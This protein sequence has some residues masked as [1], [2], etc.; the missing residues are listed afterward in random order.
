MVSRAVCGAGQGIV[1]PLRAGGRLHNFSPNAVLNRHAFRSSRSRLYSTVEN[2]AKASFTKPVRKTHRWRN[3]AIV[4]GLGGAGYL[5]DRE[6][7][8]SAIAR[9]LRCAYYG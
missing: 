6:L 4:A 5:A 3:L 2:Q 8:A 7:N 1:M 9:N